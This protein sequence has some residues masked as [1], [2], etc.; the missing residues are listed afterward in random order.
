MEGDIIR[1]CGQLWRAIILLTT[2]WFAGLERVSSVPAS[3][4]LRVFPGKLFKQSWK[5]SNFPHLLIC[6]S[7]PGGTVVKNLPT[8]AV[9]TGDTGSIPGL[10][11]SPREG[12]ATHS[13]I[14]AWR[15]PWTAEP[16]GLQS[17]GSQRVGHGWARA[18]ICHRLTLFFVFP[19]SLRQSSS[20]PEH[21]PFMCWCPFFQRGNSM[22]GLFGWGADPEKVLMQVPVSNAQW[23]QTN[24][25]TG[26]WSRE[27]FIAGPC[28]ERGGSCSSLELPEGF[29]QSTFKG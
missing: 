11:R 4:H 7:F 20:F 5:I 1:G 22:L 19:F 12:N 27:R 29:L 9:D 2:P 16:G 17:M 10:G 26:I 25:N 21:I 15:I 24:W 28:K 14:L 6:Q 8:N 3:A 23:G 18:A 13:S